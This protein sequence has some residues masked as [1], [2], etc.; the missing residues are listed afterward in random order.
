[1]QI[2]FT[3]VGHIKLD[4]LSRKI[5][6]TNCVQKV[7]IFKFLKRCIGVHYFAILSVLM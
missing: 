7:K 5:Y 1:V 6:Y 2:V 4:H 3:T